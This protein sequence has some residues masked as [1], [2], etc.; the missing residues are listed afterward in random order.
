MTRPLLALALFSALACRPPEAPSAPDP[1]LS[2]PAPLWIPRRV[3]TFHLGEF[4]RQEDATR[5]SLYRYIGPDSIRFDVTLSPGPDLSTNC[6][7]ACALDSLEATLRLTGARADGTP[8][9]RTVRTEELAARPESPWMLGRRTVS[10]TT[11]DSVVLRTE[12]HLYFLPGTRMWVSGSYE[13]SPARDAVVAEFLRHVVDAF[14][15]P[16]LS[17]PEP[18]REGILASIVGEWDYVGSPLLCGPGRHTIRVTAD[19]AS[20][21]VSTPDVDGGPARVTTYQIV[22]I[23]PGIVSGQLHVIRGFVEGETRRG[24]NGD[25]I[26]WDLVLDGADRYGW[27]RND[28]HDDQRSVDVLR[29]DRG[30]Y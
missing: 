7:L 10:R 12:R 15:T 13:E 29:C 19:S 28:W 24:A 27:H 26:M 21:E 4:Q 1:M 8:P 3:S 9:D 11:R 6:P 20:F 30:P 16:P 5:G 17:L 25:P 14:A 18:T 2:D 22:R 23:G